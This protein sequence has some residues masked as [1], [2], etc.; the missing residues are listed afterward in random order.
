MSILEAIGYHTEFDD[1]LIEEIIGLSQQTFD[2]PLDLAGSYLD[3]AANALPSEKT[4]WITRLVRLAESLVDDR[5]WP[6]PSTK[7]KVNRARAL[8]KLANSPDQFAHV[9]DA[10]NDVSGSLKDQLRYLDVLAEQAVG[11]SQE[12]R[13]TLLR[14]TWEL[15]AIK[16]V[17]DVESLIAFSVPILESLVDDKEEAF[18]A[19]CDRVDWAYQELPSLG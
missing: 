17:E 9:R 13:L 3:L 4:D 15:A 19:F 10:I 8:M 14:Q 6:R 5:A 2:Q 18:W 11:W 7:L 12:D 16:T 1:G